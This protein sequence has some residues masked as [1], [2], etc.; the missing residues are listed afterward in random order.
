MKFSEVVATVKA[1]HVAK[2]VL[3]LKKRE[4]LIPEEVGNG[5]C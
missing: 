5:V 1:F 4:F 2:A 3:S